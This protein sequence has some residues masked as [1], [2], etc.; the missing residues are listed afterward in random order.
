MTE[1]GGRV[2][3]RSVRALKAEV[4]EQVIRPLIMEAREKR[5]YGLAAS[6]LKRLTGIE[7]G[8]ALGIASGARPRDF[9]LAV[10]IQRRILEADPDLREHLERASRRQIDV[11]YIGRVAKGASG[12]GSALPWHRTR[13]RP[14]PIGVSVGH[15]AV[16]AGTLGA[17]VLHRKTKKPVILSN[18][19]VL[20]NEGAAKIGD[21]ILQPGAYDGGKRSRDRIGALLDF[22][23][24]KNGAGNL[25]DAAAASLDAEIRFDATTLTG[26]GELRGLREQML[27]P[28]DIVA[29]LGRT[30]GATRGVVTAIE[31]DDVVVSYE[32]GDLSFDRQIEIEGMDDDPFS[33]GGDSGSVIV[34]E[35]GMACAL[36]FAGSDQGASNGKGLS[37]ANE[38]GLGLDQLNLEL[39][40]ATVAS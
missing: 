5:R 31:L 20:A 30:T 23:P 26:I 28:G 37:Y 18:N 15:A 25:V 40:L 21:V 9:R 35:N 7:A 16:T 34:D 33:A 12:A 1:N 10:R 6:S 22:V 3:L 19:H 27:E 29:K 32:R 8:I 14:I 11:R 2:E 17:F 36:L 24:L 39:A 4:A 38:L 13:Q